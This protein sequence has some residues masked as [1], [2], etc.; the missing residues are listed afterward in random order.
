MLANAVSVKLSLHRGSDAYF[1][2]KVFEL[3]SL[4]C[5]IFQLDFPAL[6]WLLDIRLVE[7]S[8]RTLT[9]ALLILIMM[10]AQ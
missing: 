4:L 3:P 9:Q 10:L 8:V 1:H 6:Y 2:L 5:K 7:I